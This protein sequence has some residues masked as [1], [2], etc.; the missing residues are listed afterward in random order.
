ML[1]K[2]ILVLIFLLVFLPLVGCFPSNQA[3]II[4]SSPITAVTVGETYV[5]DV[6]A[7]DPN[8][9]TLTYSLTFKPMGMT[10]NPATG[11]IK[12]TPTAKGNYAVIVKVS[13]GALDI[14]QSFTI[15]VSKPYT[16]PPVNHAPIITSIPNLTSLV[17][18]QYTYTIEATDPDGD[19]IIYSLVSGPEGMTFD[20]PTIIWTPAEGQVGPN[21][22][23][24]KASDGKKATTQS[25][26]ITVKAVELTGIKVSPD[27]MRF[28]LVGETQLFAVNAIYS[29]GNTLN[30]TSDCIYDIE[31]GVVTID[32]EEG[33]LTAVALGKDTITIVYTP[34][35]LVFTD[36]MEVAVGPVHNITQDTYYGTIQA[37]IDEASPDD[38]IEVAS[39]TYDGNLIVYKEGLTIQS[40]EGATQ[41]IIDAS[42]VDKSEYTNEWGHS[43]NYAW[44][45]NN[46]PG[47]LRNGFD[48]WSDGV[49][50]DG[51]TII[52]AEHPEDYNQG[53][54]ILLGTISTT[55]AGFVPS[56]IDEWGGLVGAVPITV[57][58]VTVKNNIIDG[59]SDGIYIWASSGNTIEYNEIRNSKPLGGGG[60]QVYTGG[61]DNIIR[62]NTI[63]NAVDAIS[64]CGGWP[65]L[66]LDVSNTQV[67][68]NTI[69]NSTV[70]I[71]FFDILGTDVVAEE[72][73]IRDNDFGIKVESVG[74]ATVASAHLN[75][76]IRNVVGI[77][78]SASEGIFDATDNWW[79]DA[80]GPSG[81]VADPVTGTIANG[82]GD[83][84]SINV[85]FD[86]W[87]H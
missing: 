10:I 66:L 32:K 40:T 62:Y 23:K 65:N 70:G 53:I 29:N 47:L 7:T 48:I 60:I 39:G 2:R 44:A 41:T 87:T 85:N 64:I 72:N 84:V 37:A 67:I 80:S 42:E 77:Q 16:P 71:K 35:G 30:I 54:G 36:T 69:T 19:T 38:T 56:N 31:D 58:G 46:K 43:I 1:N 86:P 22:V 21:D 15:V 68:G 6:E 61:T 52:N 17:G 11:L 34:D 63:E 81:G 57:S 50:I 3:P 75:N 4:T 79:G 51:F 82:T 55:Y 8:G 33:K 9:D 73:D 49:T 28:L 27:T 24:V 74:D 78:N 59:A 5:Y 14:I 20:T 12:W 26:T 13:D 83:A 25:F 18:I 76:L 45:E